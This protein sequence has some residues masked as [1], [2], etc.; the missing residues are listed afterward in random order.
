MARPA[1]TGR[2]KTGAPQWGAGFWGV[3]PRRLLHG[4]GVDRAGIDALAAV[5]AGVADLGLAI[6]HGNGLDRAGGN[7]GFAG[8]AL[9]FVNT[10]GHGSIL[11]LGMEEKNRQRTNKKI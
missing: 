5:D 2:K 11:S 1:G 10:G 4:D 6:L 9:A 7:A 8:G 3:R